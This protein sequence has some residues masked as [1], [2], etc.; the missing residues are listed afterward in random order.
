M[1]LTE[2]QI[3]ENLQRIEERIHKAAAS[4]HRAPESVKLLVVSKRQPV[5]VVENA[6][7]A[8]VKLFGENY[9]EEI[10]PKRKA[11]S[12][13]PGVQWHMIGHVQ[14]RKVKIVA[15][16]ADYVHSIDSLE[17][18]LKLNRALEEKNRALPVLL[19]MNVSSEESK[20][21]WAAWDEN[22][23]EAL[24]PDI[25]GILACPRLQ[26]HGLMT[27]PPLEADPEMVR[28]YFSRLAR[29]RDFLAARYPAKDWR[30]LSMGTSADFEIGIQ[31]GASFIRIG[32][33]ILGPR[34]ARILS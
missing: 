1:S 12:A 7:R 32:Q 18:A 25:E 14:S 30:E 13:L 27:M 4:A 23:W 15:E 19:E 16:M 28:P 9:A 33:A 34:P 8:G 22:H 29:L 24:L 26:V 2:E 5:E 11:L 21:G 3:R 31:E 10:E 20:S 17:L 6:A